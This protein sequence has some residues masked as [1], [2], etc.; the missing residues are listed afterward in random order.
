MME[1]TA[2]LMLLPLH[3][4][5]PMGLMPGFLFKGTRLPATRAVSPEG[6]TYSVHIRM[7][8]SAKESHRSPE[9]LW[10]DVQSLLQLAA[11]TPDGPADPNTPN[12]CL[13]YTSDAADE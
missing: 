11:S 7:A 13:L 4:P 8:H 6:L 12:T 5:L 2:L 3:S 9:A 10:K 1:S